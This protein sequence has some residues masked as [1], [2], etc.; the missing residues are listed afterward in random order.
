MC[1]GRPNGEGV[2]LGEAKKLHEEFILKGRRPLQP[3]DVLQLTNP[4]Y[5]LFCCPITYNSA[6]NIEQGFKQH[7]QKYFPTYSNNLDER[8][9][10]QEL[11]FRETPNYVL[12]MLDTAEL[13]GQRETEYRPERTTAILI[14]DLRN[15]EQ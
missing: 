4:I 11:G 5:C 6:P 10:V 1:Q 2:Y 13:P 8:E 3:S 9:N 12:Q 7:L 15:G 14:I